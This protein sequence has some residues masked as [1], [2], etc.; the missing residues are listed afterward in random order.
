MMLGDKIQRLRKEKGMSQEELALQLTVSRQAVSKWELGESIPDTENVI[1]LSKLFSVSTDFLLHDEYESDKDIPAVKVSNDQI[2]KRY[3]SRVKSLSYWLIGIGML[4]I[5]AM[6]ILAFVI[7]AQK[8]VP[9]DYLNTIIGEEVFGEPDPEVYKTIEV[10]SDL[11]AFLTTYNLIPVFSLCCALAF[12]GII[13]L[14]YA[15]K[16][17]KHIKFPIN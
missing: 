17:E 5:L 4:G 6:W 8:I 13:L 12:I 16:K 1:Q 10:N 11:G 7:P 15:L 3:R 14:L 9:I 2:K